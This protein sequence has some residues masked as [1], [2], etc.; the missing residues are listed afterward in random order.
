MNQFR[1]KMNSQFK[2]VDRSSVFGKIGI[3]DGDR[4][5]M[6]RYIASMPMVIQQKICLIP[7]VLELM[8]WHY[9][10]VAARM[11]AEQ[12]VEVIRKIVRD[13]H[14]LHKDYRI[15][16]INQMSVKKFNIMVELTD[17][18][19]GGISH[20]LQILYFSVNQEFMRSVPTYPYGE[21]RCQAILSRLFVDALRDNLTDM[22]AMFR[23][24][25]GPFAPRG[26]V[27]SELK[28]LR[29]LMDGIAGVD[30]KFDYDNRNIQMAM[31]IIRNKINEIKFSI[32]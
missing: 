30:G 22:N 3:L 27:R 24:N 6:E 12:K 8:S 21:M 32:T 7:I 18:F 28:D 5:N 14:S 2:R 19:M 9:A 31:R 26:G 16:A 13:V 15:S 11:A 1:N 20:D 25:L 4:N 10:D 23:S 17:Q 29:F